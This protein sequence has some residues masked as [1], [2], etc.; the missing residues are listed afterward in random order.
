MKFRGPASGIA[1]AVALVW[2]TPGSLASDR[3]VDETCA[4]DTDRIDVHGA[5]IHMHGIG[6]PD[7]AQ[8]CL[9]RSDRPWPCGQWAAFALAERIGRCAISCKR[10]DTDR[11]GQVL[12]V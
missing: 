10:T 1:L 5:R 7:S 8:R 9:D 4:V 12:A 11:Y 6:A 3:I 2:L